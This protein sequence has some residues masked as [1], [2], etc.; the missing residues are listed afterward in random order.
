MD[1]KGFYKKAVLF[2]CVA[3]ILIILGYVSLLGENNKANDVVVNFLKNIKSHEYDRAMWEVARDANVNTDGSLPFEDYAFLLELSLK[4]VFDILD[5]DAYQIDVKRETFWLPYISRDRMKMQVILKKKEKSVIESLTA[6]G[7]YHTQYEFF[8]LKR[9]D[10]LWK[11]AE[12]KTE[13]SL[14]SEPFNSF[15]KKL[16]DNEYYVRTENGFI[17]NRF[18]FDMKNN[19]LPEKYFIKYFLYKASRLVDETI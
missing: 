10:G 1:A 15:K 12:I 16:L 2:G 19:H 13:A 5:E 8:I 7:T 14:I 9:T 11:I 6:M 4:S 18:E 3:F 17:F